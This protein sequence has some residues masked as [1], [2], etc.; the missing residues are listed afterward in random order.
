M[1]KGYLV[2]IESKEES[3]A[4]REHLELAFEKL[5]G[6]GVWLGGH[7]NMDKEWHWE[8]GLFCFFFNIIIIILCTK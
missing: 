6:F 7:K 3:D 4:V 5:L 1:E 2:Q 8:N